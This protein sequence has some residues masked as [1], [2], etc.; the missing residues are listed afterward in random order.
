MTVDETEETLA[1]FRVSRELGFLTQCDMRKIPDYYRPWIILCDAMVELV[2]NNVVREAILFLPQLDTNRLVTYEDWRTAHLLLVTIA[3]GYLWSGKPSDAPLVL[4]KNICAPLVSVSERLGLRPV[5]CHASAC[6]ANWHLIDNSQPFSPDNL[7]LNAFTFLNTKGNHWFFTV[8][9][10]IEKDFGPCTYEIVR[11]VLYTKR[12]KPY[13]LDIAISSITTCLY[14]AGKTMTRMGEFLSA[15][16][17]F[18]ELRPFLWGYNEGSLKE[19]GILFEGMEH[20]GH[21]KYG[22]GSAAQSSTIQLID[23]FLKVEHTGADNDFLIQQ[24]EYMPREHRELLEWVETSTP[25]QKFT[26]RREEAL[27]ALRAFRSKH[28]NLVAQ[29]ILS[30]IES[31][32]STTGTGGTPFVKFLKN[33]RSDTK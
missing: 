14:N 28:L 6:L 16:E 23:A 30:Q 25:V 12:G 22:G 3:S 20:L 1:R 24:R 32:A 29:Y 27:E 18:H 13:N 8:T 31:P 33:C 26:P 19:S 2:K 17:F 10:Q 9:A 4:P 5:I 7:Q 21:L 11:A 15:K